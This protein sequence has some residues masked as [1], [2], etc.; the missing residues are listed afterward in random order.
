[1]NNPQT[2]VLSEGWLIGGI[3]YQISRLTTNA[4]ISEVVAFDKIIAESLPRHG[5]NWF[6]AHGWDSYAQF[7]ENHNQVILL[8]NKETNQLLSK[9]KLTLN[10]DN[11]DET[12][13]PTRSSMRRY[14]EPESFKQDGKLALFSG[15]GTLPEH[16]DL[17]ANSKIL[18]AIYNLA[19]YHGK[20]SIA[21]IAHVD[22]LGSVSLMTKDFVGMHAKE[23]VTHPY[24][25]ADYFVM[26]RGLPRLISG[27]S[28]SDDKPLKID[29]D[30]LVQLTETTGNLGA[31][32]E[33]LIEKQKKAAP[34]SSQILLPWIPKHRNN[35]GLLCTDIT[36]FNRIAAD[37]YIGRK[38]VPVSNKSNRK[39]VTCFL[40][41]RSR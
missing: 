12:G 5:G 26:F 4:E 23:V 35:S 11:P 13:I 18:R 41:E 32:I 24:V 27:S 6:F 10:T 37:G 36:L 19:A 25:S 21:A 30:I 20:D 17:G 31:Q 1:M 14:F 15:I 34:H 28:F 29:P 38:L 3:P 40:M 7:L 22:N 8:R 9:A 2:N 33:A 39:P 16:R